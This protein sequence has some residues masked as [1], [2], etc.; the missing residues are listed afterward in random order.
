MKSMNENLTDINIGTAG[1]R[2]FYVEDSGSNVYIEKNINFQTSTEFPSAYKA[3]IFDIVNTGE[4]DLTVEFN[5]DGVAM[6]IESNSSMG[7][8]AIMP[9]IKKVN[10]ITNSTYK[11]MLRN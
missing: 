5:D 9:Y 2:I 11:L 10:I 7:K 4:S 1:Y 8:I 6:T 3:K